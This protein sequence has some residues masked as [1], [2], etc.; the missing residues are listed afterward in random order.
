VSEVRTAKTDVKVAK[1]VAE[2]LR[3]RI[4]QGELAPGQRLIES[5]L[6]DELEVSRGA[7][8]E[9]FIQLDADGLVEL[10]H[11]RGAAVTKLNRQEMADLFAVRE[12][13]EGF[14]A[15][16]AA[17]NVD[18]GANRAWL[19]AQR[20]SWMRSEMLHNEI[21]HMEENIPFHD[22][23]IQMSGNGK[24][25]EVLHRMQIPAYRQRFL[26]LLDSDRRQES[27]EDHLMVIDAIL[28]GDAAKAEEMMR[29]HVRRSG[30]L[31]LSIEGLS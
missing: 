3:A 20:E 12:R 18:E 17:Q 10:R 8:R 21:A 2:I 15:F 4:L 31:A 16:L 26:K 25:I 9:A 7:I 22:G 24:L 30:E 23:L 5:D 14:S 11:Q 29:L 13:L 27:V 19:K 6:Q 28:A 1:T